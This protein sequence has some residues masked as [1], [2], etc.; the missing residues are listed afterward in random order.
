MGKI[1]H[2]CA[3]TTAALRRAI[4]NSQES[5]NQMADRYHI[6]VKTVAKWRRRTTVND[7]PTGPRQP[8]S[9]VLTAEQE[10]MIVTFRRQTFH[11][12]RF[13]MRQM[14]QSRSALRRD[15]SAYS[16]SQSPD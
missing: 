2:G 13:K 14:R 10:A 3:A 8:H 1:L 5:L 4:Q 9:S 15:D 16:R 6:N 12:Q 11:Q 7:S